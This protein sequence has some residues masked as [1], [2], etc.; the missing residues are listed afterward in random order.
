MIY[1]LFNTETNKY[2][3]AY[4]DS[5]LMKEN[6]MFLEKTH[7]SGFKV[8]SLN[9]KTFKMKNE[10]LERLPT[11]KTQQ[12]HEIIYLL[13][14]KNSHSF[15]TYDN[16]LNYLS[17]MINF[18]DRDYGIIKT[19]LNSIFIDVESNVKYIHDEDNIIE[20]PKETVVRREYTEKEA[21]DIYEITRELNLLKQQKKRL[22]E[23]KTEYESNLKLYNKFK[24]EMKVKDA[25]IVPE[26]F[27]SK[28]K[29]FEKLE[30]E[31]EI[32]FE[33]YMKYDE[34]KFL[35]NSYELL[36]EGGSNVNINV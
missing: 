16:D 24:E 1:L 26:L 19:R 27:L 2:Y 3:G 17:Q 28:F 25:F 13:Y 7:K 5:L 30:K 23:K 33:N 4:G 29:L 12:R 15:I 14:D 9:S 31:N 8:F 6:K 11:L 20:K 22:E 10:N 36:F 21:K 18:F 35:E 32:T 34:H